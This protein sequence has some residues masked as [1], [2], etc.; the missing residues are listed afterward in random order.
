VV[1]VFMLILQL[2]VPVICKVV[3]PSLN[4]RTYHLSLPWCRSWDFILT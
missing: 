2:Q 1:I 3:S 4:Y